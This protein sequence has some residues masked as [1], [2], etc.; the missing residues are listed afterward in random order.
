[1]NGKEH[2]KLSGRKRNTEDNELSGK[3]RNTPYKQLGDSEGDTHS[4]I[5]HRLLTYLDK[6]QTGKHIHEESAPWVFKS[7]I[8]KKAY[9]SRIHFLQTDRSKSGSF[10]GLE[11]TAS[12][13]DI[14]YWLH[15]TFKPRI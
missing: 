6:V 13:T 3:K 12:P 11:D 15:Q 8:R 4:S 5:A 7:S 2:E 10:P 1:M 14:W 9:D